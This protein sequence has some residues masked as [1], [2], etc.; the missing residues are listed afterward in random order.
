MGQTTQGDRAEDGGWRDRQGRR[1]GVGTEKRG[2]GDRLSPLTVSSRRMLI[3]A[4]SLSVFLGASIGRVSRKTNPPPN[5]GFPFSPV[6]IRLDRVQSVPTA[7]ESR[8]RDGDRFRAKV[9]QGFDKREEDILHAFHLGFHRP[10]GQTSDRPSS[11]SLHTS[12]KSWGRLTSTDGEDEFGS[13]GRGT[14]SVICK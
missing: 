3:V 2:V 7:L 13:S 14:T 4:T 6:P 5:T 9:R 1:R 8:D 10:R 11:R 12:P